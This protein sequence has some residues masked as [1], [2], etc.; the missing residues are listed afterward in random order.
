MKA[1]SVFGKTLHHFEKR[2]GK[3]SYR[4]EA[5]IFFLIALFPVYSFSQENKNSFE[6]YGT[7]NTDIGYDFNSIHPDWYDM[8]RPTK[9]PSYRNEFG[10]EGNVFLSVRQIK[11]GI[12]SSRFTRLG[13]L[14]TQLDFDFIGFGKDAG[15][16]TLHLIN[17]Y[18]QLGRVGVGQTASAFM[19]PDVFP[20]T[21]DYWGPMARVFF[22]NIQLRYV[23]ID[24][25]KRRLIVA[26][27]RPGG[28][29]DG[30]DYTNSIEIQNI[31]PVFNTPNLTAHYRHYWKWGHLQIGGIAKGIKW[32][33]LDTASYDLS[34]RDFAWG[35]NLSLVLKVS[36]KV[37]LKTQGVYGKGIEN[38]IADAPADVGLESQPGNTLQPLQGKAL[39]VW[40]F[41]SF[42]EITWNKRLRSSIGYSME[43]ISNTDLQ[44]SNAFRKGQ[45]GVINLRYSPVY[46]MMFAVEYQYGRRDNFSD[47]FHSTGNKIQFSFKFNFSEKIMQ[48]D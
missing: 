26:L 43:T 19:D 23:A 14:K 22:F 42:A 28:K 8:M 27:E 2:A 37:T 41:F 36:K 34:G 17:A 5:I 12:K 4:D 47:G 39:P 11:L 13:E 46:V 29:A 9:L 3:M 18:A 6:L 10:T 7:I 44:S 32:K 40:G 45:Y 21:L 24:N 38:Y 16:T 33:D 48:G 20:E 31:K 1:W 15:Q 35:G 30:G 25:E